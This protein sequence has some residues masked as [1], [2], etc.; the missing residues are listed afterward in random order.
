MSRAVVLT[1]GIG[2]GKSAVAEVLAEWGA[3]VVDAD[4][5]AREVVAP[6]TDGFAAVV[7]EFGPT[8][9]AS[10]G[11]LDRAALADV[12]FSQ[13]ERLAALEAIVHPRVAAL[14][15]ARLAEKPD[16]PV[17]VYE[18]PLPDR[19]PAFRVSGTA[20]RATEPPLVVVVDASEEERRRR[21]LA[22]GLEDVQIASRMAAQPSRDEWLS[23][24]DILVDNGGE[25]GATV[26]QLRRLWR[27]LTGA[28]AP[29]GPEG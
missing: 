28:P 26:Q 21:L 19:I 5:L 29:V 8:V 25:P 1:G 9:V 12:V 17:L 18:V 4:Q 7:A 16:A 10:D 23:L 6:G 20:T 3:H 27:Q 14:A 13:P 11:S 2:S 24:A 15:S 22:R